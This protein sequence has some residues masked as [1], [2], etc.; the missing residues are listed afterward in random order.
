MLQEA[1][2][3]DAHAW[4]L[5]ATWDTL[6]PAA[7][8]TRLSSMRFGDL[9]ASG[10]NDA[11]RALSDS[12]PAVRHQAQWL[13]EN[14]TDG[15][16]RWRAEIEANAASAWAAHALVRGDLA[17][18]ERGY[19]VLESSWAQGRVG[20][21]QRSLALLIERDAKWRDTCEAHLRA[22]STNRELHRLHHAAAG[23]LARVGDADAS[24][25]LLRVSLDP[26]CTCVAEYLAPMWW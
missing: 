20:E 18:S 7:R 4:A 9:D 3:I 12:S 16:D 2:A 8:I 19:A 21:Q 13:I 14:R 6:V 15:L 24:T 26:A 5:R 22:P 25:R 17:D 1:H 10:V 23:A 11:R